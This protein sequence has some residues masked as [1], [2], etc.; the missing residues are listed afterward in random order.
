MSSIAQ[1]SLRPGRSIVMYVTPW[2]GDCRRARRWFDTHGISYDT[3]NI[4]KDEQ[5]AAYV[6][7]VNSGMRSVPTIVFPD[8]SVLVEPTS[9][10]LAAK[11]FP[12][13]E[14]P[15]QGEGRNTLASKKVSSSLGVKGISFPRF[16]AFY[17]WVMGRPLV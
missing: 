17:N 13:G 7:Q 3:I 8:G 4:E 9:R 2:C 14:R 11:C 1:E 16:A 10:E 5:A 12:D 15:G 6:M